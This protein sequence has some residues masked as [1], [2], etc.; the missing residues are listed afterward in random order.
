MR[1]TGTF[2]S[3][4]WNRAIFTTNNTGGIR[5]LTRRGRLRFLRNASRQ[6]EFSQR[7]WRPPVWATLVL[8]T[9]WSEPPPRPAKY[10]APRGPKDLAHAGNVANRLD[11]YPKDDICDL[12]PGPGHRRSKKDSGPR[13]PA[14][15]PGPPCPGPRPGPNGASLHPRSVAIFGLRS[16]SAL[17]FCRTLAKSN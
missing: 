5:R 15:C 17:P 7:A 16:S 4:R 6:I 12:G 8:P 11:G 10:R 14:T 13:A 9:T 2:G 3:A 1:L